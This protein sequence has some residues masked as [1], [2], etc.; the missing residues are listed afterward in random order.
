MGAG[1]DVPGREPQAPCYSLGPFPRGR[2][3]PVF[4]D[5][6]EAERAQSSGLSLHPTPVPRPGCGV[7]GATRGRKGCDRD[8]HVQPLTFDL[9]EL[10]SPPGPSL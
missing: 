1:P 8:L 7:E 6:S 4:W 9:Y 3:Y 5:L 10:S 2:T